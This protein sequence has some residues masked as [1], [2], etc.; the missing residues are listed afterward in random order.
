MTKRQEFVEWLT[1]GFRGESAIA[2]DLFD[3]WIDQVIAEA[4]EE[5]ALRTKQRADDDKLRKA[6][7]SVND[8][9]IIGCCTNCSEWMRPGFWK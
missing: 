7:C 3:H 8:H 5:E 1:R 4:M 2:T 9:H 6:G